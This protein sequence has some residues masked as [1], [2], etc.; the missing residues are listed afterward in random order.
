MARKLLSETEK[1]ENIIKSR[2]KSDKKRKRFAVVYRLDQDAKIEAHYKQKGFTSANSYLKHLI[3]LDMQGS[4]LDIGNTD[5][6]I[7]DTWQ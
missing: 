6:E 3:E 2:K 4:N 1:R 7:I 5:R